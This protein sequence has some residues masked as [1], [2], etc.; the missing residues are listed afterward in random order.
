MA[1]AYTKSPLT[2]EQQSVTDFSR[3]P[4]THITRPNKSKRPELL[5][6]NGNAAVVV[7]DSETYEKIA[8]LAN[9]AESVR[10]IRH[11]LSEQGR[12]LDEF[13][14]EFEARHDINR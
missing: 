14:A 10:I 11:A 8:V 4:A 7:Q 5:T 1:E 9:Y 13:T 2:F 12:P 6:V 3:K